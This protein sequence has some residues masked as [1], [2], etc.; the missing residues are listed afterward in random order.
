[1]R[2]IHPAARKGGFTGGPLLGAHQKLTLH[3]VS[4]LPAAQILVEP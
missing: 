1:M 3:G 4:C 2:S